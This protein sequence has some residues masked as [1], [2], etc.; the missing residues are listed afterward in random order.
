MRDQATD[1]PTRGGPLDHRL[2][3]GNKDGV[4]ET[5][6]KGYVECPG[7]FGFVNLAL[8]VFHIGYFK[9]VINILQSICK[10][11]SRLLLPEGEQKAKFAKLMR[12]RKDPIERETIRKQIQDECK[13][14]KY[15]PH[16]QG[17]N[18][19][20]KRVVGQALR[21]VHDKFNPKSVPEDVM[22]DLIEEF[23][24][25][26][27]IKG[28]ANSAAQQDFE[29]SLSKSI[30]DLHAKMAY[31][32]F[33]G[34]ADEDMLFLNMNKDLCRPTDLILTAIPVPPSCIRPTVAVGMGKTNEDDLTMKIRE[35]VERNKSIELGIAE[36]L[37]PHRLFEEHYLLSCSVG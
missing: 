8:P 22:N 12:T 23:Q 19:Q 37:E 7:H 2:G 36:G 15:C 11:C 28:D 5:C 9:H 35:I 33:Q 20:V 32:L 18:G 31:D 27:Q 10:D 29:A 13:K 4:C 21:V 16:C 30:I 24:F 1:L 3:V 26:C 34:I 14:I 6:G 25:S 17:Y